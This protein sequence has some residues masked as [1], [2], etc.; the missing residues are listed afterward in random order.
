MRVR[1]EHRVSS[2]SARAVAVG[3]MPAL[4]P[5]ERSTPGRWPWS[6]RQ[7]FQTIQI[8]DENAAQSIS[9]EAR[10]VWRYW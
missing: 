7:W 9:F 2:H 1:S 8:I 4:R 10:R 5:P 6:S 3:S